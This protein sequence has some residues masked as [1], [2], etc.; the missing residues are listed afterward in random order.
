MA[1]RNCNPCGSNPSGGTKWRSCCG[2]LGPYEVTLNVPLYESLGS[3]R[4]K[5]LLPVLCQSQD[6]I[7]YKQ[8]DVDT[9]GG[10]AKGIPKKLVKLPLVEP[11]KFFQL[12]DPSVSA[13]RS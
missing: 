10:F 12:R 5:R 1:R 11:V 13:D 7:S 9:Y 4:Q 6:V 3:G 8:I 2:Q